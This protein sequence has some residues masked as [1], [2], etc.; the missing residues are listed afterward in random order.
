LCHGG[1]GY[2]GEATIG[3][4][5][6][7]HGIKLLFQRLSVKLNIKLHAHKLRH[8]FSTDFLNNEES[9]AD[10]VRILGH[11]SPQMS[12]YYAHITNTDAVERQKSNCVVDRQLRA[13]SNDLTK[14][15]LIR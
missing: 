14:N 13:T 8:T 15:G 10:L 9:V 5:L 7:A 1:H 2:G 3:E 4:P 12:L 6:S 11:E